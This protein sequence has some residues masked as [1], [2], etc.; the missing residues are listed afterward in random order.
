MKPFNER[1]KGRHYK[2][3]TTGQNLPSVTNILDCYPKQHALVHWAANRQKAFDVWAAYELHLR[4][5][6]G[7]IAF[8]NAEAYKKALDDY[9]GRQRAHVNELEKAGALGTKIH[10]AVE[11]NMKIILGEDYEAQP[12]LEGAVLW[13]FMAF[14]DWWNQC[15][16]T[17]LQSEIFLCSDEYGYAGTT[18]LIA[19]V[20][21]GSDNRHYVK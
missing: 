11:A 7:A 17:P 20:L 1:G 13:A 21:T 3:P 10:K 5:E 12:D 16:I 19:W 2:S 6:S 8:A 9:I 15:S 4:V 14:E 18:D